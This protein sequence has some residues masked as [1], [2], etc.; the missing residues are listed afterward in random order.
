MKKQI[1][2]P[3]QKIPF[4]LVILFASFFLSCASTRQI[5][6]YNPYPDKKIILEGNNTICSDS[7]ER[8]LWFILY[9]NYMLNHINAQDIFPSADYTYKIEQMTTVGDKILSIF[10]GIFFTINRKTLIVKT[11]QVVKKEN[12][13]AP[14]KQPEKIDSKLGDL[15]KEV[16]FLK[17]KISGIETTV[18][19]INPSNSGAQQVHSPQQQ[20]NSRSMVDDSES[21]TSKILYMQPQGVQHHTL[22]F[23]RNS[24]QIAQSDR[25][26]I[27]NLMDL[28][29]SPIPKILIIGSTDSIGT[30][31]K[32]LSL[33]L[34]RA[35]AVKKEMIWLGI[36]KEKIIISGAGENTESDS[37]KLESSRRVDIYFVQGGEN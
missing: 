24:F 21:T 16:S 8:K 23:K 3:I 28:F 13:E 18:G 9:G 7:Y 33:S 11:C 20:S 2:F 17:G 29:H 27:K 34:K 37:G 31:K 30:F 15:E 36:P 22:L 5:D 1:Q 25:L 14:Q 6:I 35:Q 19:W 4:F 26:K 32:N 10:T 12:P